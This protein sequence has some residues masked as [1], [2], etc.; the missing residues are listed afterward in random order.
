MLPMN[1]TY[2]EDRLIAAISHASALLPIIGVAIPIGV[3]I[4]QKDRSPLLKFQS[5]QAL[6]YQI[7]AI[8]VYFLLMGC[9]MVSSLAVF[10]VMMGPLAFFNNSQTQEVSGV[11][12]VVFLIS[13]GV[14]CIVGFFFNVLMWVGGPTYI[15]IALIG[16]RKVL[17]GRDF[18]YP[19]LGRRIEK[20]LGHNTTR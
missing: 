7:I 12:G 17:N 5:L 3:W 15:I 18:Y 16:A 6:V 19:I 4:S 11:I 2:R 14:L 1:D 13:M 9:Q 10:P 8:V 20:R